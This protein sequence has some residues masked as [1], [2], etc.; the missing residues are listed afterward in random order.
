MEKK[1]QTIKMEERLAIAEQCFFQ[2]KYTKDRDWLQKHLHDEFIECGKSNQL[3]DKQVTIE[4]LLQLKED[5][6]ITMQDFSCMRVDVHTWMV[7][8]TTLHDGQLFYRTSLWIEN[9]GLQLLFH[10]A[11]LLK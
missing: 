2:L 10:Q 9:D 4:S 1:E 6:K 8:Y 11:T 7:H 3:Y 5:R